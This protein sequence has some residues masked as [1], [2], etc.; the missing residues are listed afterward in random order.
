MAL[1]AIADI[2]RHFSADRLVIAAR[3]AVADLFT[4][5]PG[6][7]DVL[8]LT[9]NGRWWNRFARRQDAVRLASIAADVA[10]LLPNSFAT[11]WLVRQAAIRERWGYATDMRR[12]LLSRAVRRPRQSMHQGAYYQHLTSRLGIPAGP[13]EPVASFVPQATG[14]ARRLLVE[15]GWDGETPLAVLAP[16]AAYG[17]AKRWIPSHVA[18]LATDL[19]RRRGM[20]CV[21]V[22]SRA[23]RATTGAVRALMADDARPRVARC[24][25]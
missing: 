6:V 25:G 5:V 9:W 10:I 3:P 18:A 23:D 2:R 19:V 12:R 1:P 13:L 14:A 15:R 24:R 17:T 4:L 16:G 8:R 21:L 22:G 11:A 7:D 20:T